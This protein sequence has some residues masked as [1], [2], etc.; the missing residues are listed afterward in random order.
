M[1]RVSGCFPLHL[2]ACTC[3]SLLQER[4]EISLECFLI[5]RGYSAKLRKHLTSSRDT[6]TSLSGIIE[7]LVATSNNYNKNNGPQTQL[8]L[9]I[10]CYA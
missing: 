3:V 6:K 9:N 8:A 10:L 7:I 2:F 5:D 4:E 1:L